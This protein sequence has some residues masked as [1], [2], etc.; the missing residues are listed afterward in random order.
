MD[1]KSLSTDEVEAYLRKE[2][3]MSER[4]I[5]QIMTELRFADKLNKAGQ[6]PE[7]Y[8]VDVKDIPLR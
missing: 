6:L 4:E 3:L 1:K 7:D 2:T 8:H 5:H